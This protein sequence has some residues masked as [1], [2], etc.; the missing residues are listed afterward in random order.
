MPDLVVLLLT[1]HRILHMP[2][3]GSACM[4]KGWRRFL[5]GILESSGVC[6]WSV[7]LLREVRTLLSKV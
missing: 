2:L 5:E 6:C 4:G 7:E 1:V 3:L